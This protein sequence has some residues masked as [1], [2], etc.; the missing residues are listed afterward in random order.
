MARRSVRVTLTSR[1]MARIPD[2]LVEGT[3]LALD[4]WRTGRLGALA[5][6][7]QIRRQGGYCGL[8]VWLHLWLFFCA[9]A[10]IGI[11]T[12]WKRTLGAVSRRVASVV[13]RRSLASPASLSRA[14]GAVELDLL[15]PVAPQLLHE[16]PASD[17]RTIESLV[18]ER[19][20]DL[21][22]L[23]VVGPGFLYMMVRNVT[24]CLVEVGEGRREP[25]WVGEILAAGDRR[26]LPAPAPARGL[27]LEHV[28]YGDGFGG[29]PSA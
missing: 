15:R 12:F 27:T 16:L 28:A 1:D 4:L 5:E 23:D 29:A 21:L 13:A 2:N 9:G 8:D 20:L 22:H 19:R 10:H 26:R 24:A 3:L 17:V 11:R 7:L 6:C 18:A 25:A 14:L